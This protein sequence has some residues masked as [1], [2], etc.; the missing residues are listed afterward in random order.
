MTK[1]CFTFYLHLITLS[2]YDQKVIHMSSI[3]MTLVVGINQKHLKNKSLNHLVN[4][5]VVTYSS[6]LL[7]SLL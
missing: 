1:Y 7:Q 5:R 4:S 2:K 6:H 3:I